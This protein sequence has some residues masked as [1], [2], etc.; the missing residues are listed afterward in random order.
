MND[1]FEV[2]SAAPAGWDCSWSE[3]GLETASIATSRFCDADIVFL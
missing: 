1:I 3:T 2:F